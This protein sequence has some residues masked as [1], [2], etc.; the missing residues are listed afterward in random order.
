[1][2]LTDLLEDLSAIHNRHAKIADN[3]INAWIAT[4][5]AECLRSGAK[6]GGL[7]P[8]RLQH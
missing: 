8:Q 5:I 1:M 6:E 2:L 7:M 4:E 3:D